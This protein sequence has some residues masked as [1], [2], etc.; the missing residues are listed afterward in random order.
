MLTAQKIQKDEGGEKNT[1]I[2]SKFEPVYR[3]A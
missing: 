2:L 3:C 1:E